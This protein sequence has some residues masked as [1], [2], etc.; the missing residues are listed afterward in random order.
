MTAS[1]PRF[2]PVPRGYKAEPFPL[3]DKAEVYLFSDGKFR[4]FD[5]FWEFLPDAEAEWIVGEFQAGRAE[6]VGLAEAA[7]A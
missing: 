1:K 6:L 3:C 5:P 2:Q 4:Q 7:L